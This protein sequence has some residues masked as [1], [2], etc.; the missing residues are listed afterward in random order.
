MAAQVPRIAGHG[1]W[2][3]VTN[4][5]FSRRPADF[6]GAG[7]RATPEKETKPMGFLDTIGNAIWAKLEPRVN[8]LLDDTVALIQREIAEQVPV[9]VQAAVAAGVKAG[10]ELAAS[11]VDK[12]TDLI[13]GQLDDQII[14][15][16]VKGI[17]GDFLNNLGLGPRSSGGRKP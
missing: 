7:R 4:P 2:C 15:P 6:S 12:V 10:T 11:G 5:P 13:P 16:L 8:K 1:I 9:L 3:A 17:L 14:D